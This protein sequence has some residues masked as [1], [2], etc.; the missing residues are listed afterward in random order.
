MLLTTITSEQTEMLIGGDSLLPTKI[1]EDL[2]RSL[3]NYF[4]FHL[5]FPAGYQ[6]ITG[7]DLGKLIIDHIRSSQSGFM[8]VHN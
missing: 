1:L 3:N 8:L 2:Q 7:L 4:C 5:L 6:N